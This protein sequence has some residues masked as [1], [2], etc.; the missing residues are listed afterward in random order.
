MRKTTILA[1]STLVLVASICILPKMAEGAQAPR[2]TIQEL[3]KNWKRYDGKTVRLRGRL[4]TCS[5]SD[6]YICL[7]D[8]TPETYDERSMLGCVSVSFGHQQFGREQPDGAM[9]LLTRRM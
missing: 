9:D 2:V 3:K 5:G 6:C 1:L 7:E 8:I 4:N